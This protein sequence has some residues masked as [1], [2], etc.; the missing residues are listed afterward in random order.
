MG[1]SPADRATVRVFTSPGSW[2]EGAATDQLNQLARRRG[3]IAVAGLPDL[4]PG[5]FGPVGCAALSRGF[6]HPDIVGSDI[7]CGMQL[8]RLGLPERRLKIDKAAE[9]MADFLEGP[10]ADAQAEAEAA[11]I[12][13]GDH[14]LALGTV[15]GGNHFCE[16]Q[17]VAEVVDPEL[18]AEHGLERGA[19][20]LLV[21][22]GSRGLGRAVFERHRAQSDGLPLD[23][24]GAAY[25]ADHDAAVRFGALNRRVIA[26]RACHALRCEGR[27]LIDSPHNLA[28]RTGDLVLHRKG[29][30]PAD[31]GLLVIPGS[32]D[33]HSYVVA[34]IQGDAEAL[35]SVAH[36]AGRKHTRTAMRKGAQKTPLRGK[37]GGRV[38]CTDPALRVEE[39]PEAYKPI[40]TVID[41][42][43]AFGLI[44]VVALMRPVITFK[45]ARTGEARA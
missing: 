33:A 10:C 42:L 26:R 31:R 37:L 25:L 28:E 7:G 12:E 2:I 24:A 4:H 32:R 43:V 35:A 19:L 18:C 44:R 22:S 17:A 15:G 1:N 20:A 21:H 16:L 23:G 14:V 9:R 6:V 34:P 13:P 3:M 40:E 30:A 27:E 36:G 41:S 29:A 39:A 8:H 11:G 5:M 45:T 38:I